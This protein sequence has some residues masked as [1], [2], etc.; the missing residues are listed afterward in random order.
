MTARRVDARSLQSRSKVPAPAPACIL[1]RVQN[2]Y[3]RLTELRPTRACLFGIPS[4]S[5][6][7]RHLNPGSASEFIR[8]SLKF[9]R[10]LPRPLCMPMTGTHPKFLMKIPHCVIRLHTLSLPV[11]SSPHCRPRDPP[12]GPGERPC[13][14]F[15]NLCMR[16]GT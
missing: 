7:Q 14:P 15:R 13:G 10:K 9:A 5:G 6:S 8:P 1:K 12:Y 3:P 4:R 11:L 2:V 16:I